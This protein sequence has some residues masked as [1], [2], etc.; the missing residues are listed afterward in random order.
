MIDLMNTCSKIKKLDMAFNETG[1]EQEDL[2][3]SM[4]HLSIFKNDEF[5]SIIAEAKK[6]YETQFIVSETS[7]LVSF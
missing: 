4:S 7:A 1:I 2:N 3:R 5:K 6:R